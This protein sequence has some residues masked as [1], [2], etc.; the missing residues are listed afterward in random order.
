M[1]RRDCG[2]HKVGRYWHA[3][4]WVGGIHVHRTTHTDNIDLA[5]KLARDWR[6]SLVAQLNGQPYDSGILVKDLF[7]KWLV[8]AKVNH[9]KSHCDRV[10]ADWTHH[11]LPHVGD[12]QARTLANRDAEWLR[13]KFL[14]E[15]SRRNEHIGKALG[16]SRTEE[17][18]NKVMRH[19]RLVFRW[20]VQSAQVLSR[21]PFQVRVEKPAERPKSFLRADQ[22]G[23]FLAAVDEG[24]SLH[25]KVAVRLMLYLGLREHEALGADWSWFSPDL[26]EV[27]PMGKTGNAP[28][29]PV[30]IQLRPWL[31]RLGPKPAGLLMP[32]EDGKPHRKRYTVKAIERG[33]AAVGLAGKLS[34]HRMRGSHATILVRSGAEAHLVQQALRHDL[35]ETSQHYVRLNTDDLAEA[36]DRAFG[37]EADVN[38]KASQHAHKLVKKI[39]R[40]LVLSQLK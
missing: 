3:D 8:W 18:A 40:K 5:L 14:S 27:S 31:R 22:V 28:P 4:F 39:F 12:R 6:D 9:S 7:A 32:A 24:Y 1:A 35:L 37:G 19:L 26:A 15:P 36:Y 2:L 13:T 21:V 38:K 23:Q 29:L 25:L 16:Q 17:G 34:P 10:E 33:A 30:P 11:I 20:G